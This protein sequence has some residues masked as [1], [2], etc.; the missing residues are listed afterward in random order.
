MYYCEMLIK[1][2]VASEVFWEISGGVRE[3]FGKKQR[4]K[5]TS[6]KRGQTN[7]QKGQKRSMEGRQILVSK[8][9]SF[10]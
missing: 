2:Q 6:T 4:E 8:K 1:F 7:S 5:V 10:L 3:D 9:G